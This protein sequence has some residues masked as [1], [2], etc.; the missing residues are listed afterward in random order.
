MS[1]FLYLC[2]L[3]NLWFVLALISHVFQLRDAINRRLY[4]KYLFIQSEPQSG[5]IYFLNHYFLFD[6]RKLFLVQ[7]LY[8]LGVEI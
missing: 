8:K 5:S 6:I 7:P 1:V 4:P 3:S 2:N